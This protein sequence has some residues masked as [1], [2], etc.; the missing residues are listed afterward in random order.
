VPH[1]WDMVVTLLCAETKDLRELARIAGAN[2]KTFYHGVDPANLDLVGQD[3]NGIEFRVISAEETEKI[4]SATTKEERLSMLL[5][6]ILQN[7]SNGLQILDNYDLDKSSYANDA[8]KELRKVLTNE[9]KNRRV[10]N[11]S[12]VRALRRPLAHQL[13]GSRANLIYY[14]AKHLSKYPDIKGYLR[15]SYLRSTASQFDRYRHE[16]EKLLM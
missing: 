14:M 4:R 5:D 12:L 2:P 6:S 8:L 13:G 9:P 10:D 3:L 11:V 1:W 16:I 7:R 15:K